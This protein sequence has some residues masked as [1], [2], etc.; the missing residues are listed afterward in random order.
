M[1]SKYFKNIEHDSFALYD[2]IYKTMLHLY[3]KFTN[4]IVYVQCLTYHQ[5]NRFDLKVHVM[6]SHINSKS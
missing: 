1:I 6:A 3:L 2:N 5:A 4:V